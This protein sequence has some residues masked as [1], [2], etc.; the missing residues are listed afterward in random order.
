VDPHGRT[1]STLTGNGPEIQVIKRQLS[2]FNRRI[3]FACEFTKAT[4]DGTVT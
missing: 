2:K 1:Y 3:F 4:S